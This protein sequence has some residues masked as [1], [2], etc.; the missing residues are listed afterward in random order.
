MTPQ[1]RTPTKRTPP[2][3]QVLELLLST[4]SLSA[5]K[6]VLRLAAACA[7]HRECL[8]NERVVNGWLRAVRFGADAFAGDACVGPR[9]WLA[10]LYR[11]AR[12]EG[13]G[14]SR[15]QDWHSLSEPSSFL[16]PW[17]DVVSVSGLFVAVQMDGGVTTW[18]PCRSYQQN[19]GRTRCAGRLLQPSTTLGEPLLRRVAKDHVALSFGRAGTL[20]TGRDDAAAMTWIFNGDESHALGTPTPRIV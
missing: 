20:R 5:A 16:Q 18:N 15:P 11:R 14:R 4:T 19:S 10:Q 2:P 13:L 6:D 3:S 17:R 12:L 1:P 8:L 7:A 9:A